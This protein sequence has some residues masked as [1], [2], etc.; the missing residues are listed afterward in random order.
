MVKT[1]WLGLVFLIAIGGLIAY[2]FATSAKH[3]TAS[4]DPA[5]V[6]ADTR[7]APSAKADRLDVNYLEDLPDKTSVHTIPIVL[8]EPAAKAGPEKVTKIISR[9]WHEGYARITKR[10][11]RRQQEAS[12][13]RHRS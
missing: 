2:N 9:H 7:G 5:A 8:S 3:Q 10:S 12:R 13:S 6:N 11:I 4:A 1:V